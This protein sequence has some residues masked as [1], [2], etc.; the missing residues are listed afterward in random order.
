MVKTVIKNMMIA[1]SAFIFVACGG[2]SDS[3]P[4]AVVEDSQATDTSTARTVEE[5]NVVLSADIQGV[6]DGPNS[7]LT[8]DV[9]DAIT[10]MYNEE[11]L[12]Y[13]VYMNIN[14]VQAVNQLKK[15]ASGEQNGAEKVH[16]EAVN[17]LAIKY[18]LNMTQYPD[19]DVPCSIEGVS[20]GVYP[21]EHI[22]ELYDLLYDKGIQSKKDAL[23]VGCMVE[24]VDIDDLDKYIGF[25]EASNAGDVLKVFNFL[26]DGS[27]SH[28]W[29]FNDGLVKMGVDNG[30]CSVP[31]ALGY[32]FCHNEYP[33]K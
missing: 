19:T 3:V 31:D 7:T 27:Y 32:N 26:R 9:K 17:Q 8:Q 30:C 22:Q 12:A 23:E 5:T 6:I 10:Y 33:R 15:I 25:A 2:S 28:Y 14:K 29:A 1:T 20:S 16:I 18:D 4:S 13:D 24:V 21:V 11:G